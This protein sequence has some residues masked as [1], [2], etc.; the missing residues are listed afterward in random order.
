M[1]QL[2]GYQ[3]RMGL[4]SVFSVYG[5]FVIYVDHQVQLLDLY[6]DKSVQYPRICGL[7]KALSGVIGH[8][9]PYDHTSDVAALKQYIITNQS[10]R[11]DWPWLFK[12][13]A[14]F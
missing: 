12:K 7:L 9:N 8:L 2:L 11:T 14:L 5:Y 13:T 3:N 6:P 4:G 10:P 1:L